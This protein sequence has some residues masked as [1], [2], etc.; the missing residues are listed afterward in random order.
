MFCLSAYA[1]VLY[2]FAIT[3]QVGSLPNEVDATHIKVIVIGPGGEHLPGAT[4]RI[5]GQTELI[6]TDPKGEA[7][8][9][10]RNQRYPVDID[11]PYNNYRGKRDYIPS[12]K[13]IVNI[14]TNQ[15]LPPPSGCPKIPEKACKQVWETYVSNG[16]TYT[17][18][19]MVPETCCREEKI[20]PV[21][22]TCNKCSVTDSPN[23]RYF[24][25]QRCNLP[26]WQQPPL[27]Y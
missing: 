25:N 17:I 8:L 15:P 26:P 24:S 7:I 6:S 23:Y 27:G 16:V 9:P 14:N 18:R 5:E 19:K 13:Q 1:T 21:C 12:E 22:N 3:S 4:I 20:E 10:L 11:V 2:A